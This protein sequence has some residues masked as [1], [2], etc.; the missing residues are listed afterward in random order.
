MSEFTPRC[1][2]SPDGEVDELIEAAVLAETDWRDL[3]M[4]VPDLAYEG[5][6]EQVDRMLGPSSLSVRE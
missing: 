2:R 5:W 1:L 4:A 6:E 3:L